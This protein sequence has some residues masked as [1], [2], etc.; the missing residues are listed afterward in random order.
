MATKTLSRSFAGGEISEQLFSR[1]DLDKY[2]TGAAL[3]LNCWALPQGAVQN[4]AGFQYVRQTKFSN[5]R[6]RLLPFAYST[7]QTFALEFGHQYVRFHT[8]GATLLEAGLTITGITNASPGEVTVDDIHMFG[9]GDQLFIQGAPSMPELNNRWVEVGAATTAYAFTLRDMFGN[10]IDTT[11]FGAFVDGSA[12]V[13]R[14]YQVA[15][16]YQEE[17]L[18]SLNVVQSADVLT[19][20]SPFYAPA[21]LRRLGA[22]EWKLQEIVFASSLAAP[23]TS[24]AVPAPIFH[25]YT[26]IAVVPDVGINTIEG[27]SIGISN[28][29]TVPGYYNVIGWVAQSGAVAYMI[30]KYDGT[31]WRQIGMARTQNQF[32][33]DGSQAM[34]QTPGFYDADQVLPA[35]TVSGTAV[36]P[37][38]AGVSVVPT[39]GGSTLYRYVVTSF[40]SASKEESLASGE[41]SASNDLNTLGNVNTIRWPAVP[42]VSEYNVYRYSNGLWGFIGSAGSDC[43]FI[44]N[45]ILPETSITPPIQISPF[46]GAENFPRAVSYHEQRRVFGGTIKQPQNLWMTR[47]G[48][49]KNL[50]YSIPT[51]DDDGITVRVVAREANTIRHIVPMGDMMLLT[52]GGEWKV[53]ASDGGALTPSNVSVKPQGYTGSSEVPPVVT[54]RTIL[55]PQDRGG[56]I[57][58]LEFS[59]ES[60]GYQTTDVSILA[61]H[62]FDYFTIRQIAFSRSPVPMLWSVR[63]DGRLLAMTYVPEHEVRAWSQYET[64]GVVESVCCIAEGDEDVPY[65]IV[66]RTV[67]E[68]EYRFVERLHTRRFDR[69]V[70]QFFVDS[71]LTYDGP[72]VSVVR[73]LYH[74]EGRTVTILADGGVSPPQVVTN[75]RVS[76]EAPASV[77]HVGLP[78]RARVQTLPMSM[79]AQAFGQGT[80][81]SINKVH[82]RVLR[83]NGFAAGPSFDKLRLY[84]ARFTEPYGSPP[85]L[86]SDEVEITVDNRWDRNG[87]ICIE[88]SQPLSF[89]LLGMTLEAAVGG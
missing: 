78:Y 66:R 4:R 88:Q 32:I 9:V 43:V 59:W 65:I 60:Q 28:D 79:Q 41:A 25:Q 56:H 81:K 54:N 70:D 55:F 17:H 24:G 69:A 31:V 34:S 89:M 3:L 30:Y 37:A 12:T 84:P 20:C 15:T 68:A 85:D 80:Q 14:I 11:A 35:L 1:V 64:D 47:S 5:R 71:G 39:G 10:P 74:L 52:S 40:S 21:E 36:V 62:L 27:S 45:N 42:G 61:P 46:N 51:R 29:L 7:Q 23:Q 67:G 77:I 33:D 26:V 6:A 22:A 16:L 72:P 73:G 53:A 38:S 44:D 49:E 50:G 82:L 8:G 2:Q 48:T 19:I 75:G 58:E 83:S 63:S 87:Q 57:R 86:V 13:S 76:I 18:D